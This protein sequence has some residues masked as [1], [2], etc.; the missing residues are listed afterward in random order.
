MLVTCPK[1]QFSRE[2]PEDKIP[3]RAQV[4]TCPKC[5]H[6][7]R[8]RELPPEGADA[9]SVAA[10]PADAA[11]TAESAETPPPA[12][13]APPA[14]EDIWERLGSIQPEQTEPQPGP[15]A[16]D[17]FA[18]DPERPEVE[19]PFERLDQYGFFPGITQTLRRVLFSPQLFF[20]A[21]PLRGMGKPLTFAVLLGQFQIFF[22]ILW[23]M[24][25]IMGDK[26][27]VAPGTLGIGMVVALVLAPLFLSVFLFLESA[28]FHFCLI[29]FRAANKG[30][31]GTFRVMAY[32]NAPLILSF[33]PVLGPIA[34]Y[35]WGLGIT[36]VGAR[37]MHGASLGRVLG[38]FVL[39]LVIVGGVMGL[40][41]YAAAT[42]PPAAK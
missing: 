5:K 15:A 20:Q 31:E 35:L 33:V 40:M 14:E 23:S 7:F 30:F 2:L 24:T 13:P 38:A 22:Q 6:K 34:A 8:F 4:A 9:A 3:A 1:C 37:H 32:S 17:P 25:G 11:P 42:I 28:L 27:E 41:F 29:L 12:P 26:P 21:M 18:A 39:L 36:V 19:A 10:A 16:D